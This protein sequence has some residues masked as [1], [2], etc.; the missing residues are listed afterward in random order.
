MNL[1][2]KLLFIIPLIPCFGGAILAND[3]HCSLIDDDSER[4]ACHL[5][6]PEPAT[7][8]VDGWFVAE[9]RAMESAVATRTATWRVICGEREDTVSISL[10]CQE[11]QMSIVLSTAC[12][13]GST[14]D[15]SDVTYRLDDKDPVTKSFSVPRNTRALALADHKNSIVFVK[16][17]LEQ[18]RL[19]VTI[20]PGEHEPFAAT[21]EISGLAEK[22]KPL[23]K[24]CD[25]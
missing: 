13:M 17:L 21:F 12:M 14:G 2:R 19:N 22:I 15:D 11:K 20:K 8:K 18:D 24:K 10:I 7:S 4:I 3:I 5:K 1:K 9:S 6:L 16:S 25:W 23:R